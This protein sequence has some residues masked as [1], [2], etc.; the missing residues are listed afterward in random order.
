MTDLDEDIADLYLK[1]RADS[2]LFSTIDVNHILEKTEKEHYLENK[3]LDDISNDIFSEIRNLNLTEDTMKD[4]CTRLYGYRHVD[5]VCDLR[6]G[7]FMRWIKKTDKKLTNGGLLINVKLDVNGTVL[8]CKNNSNR[9]FNVR[10]DDCIIFQKLTM[11][12]QFIL[13]ANI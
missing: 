12:E 11:E 13:L 2:T 6:N 1:A 3:S 4:Y 9:F 10:F 7:R 8:L 5:R